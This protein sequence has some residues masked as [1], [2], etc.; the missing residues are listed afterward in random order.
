MED[1]SKFQLLK[2]TDQ[3]YDCY[4]LYLTD[5]TD[6]KKLF[7]TMC[8]GVNPLAEAYRNATGFFSLSINARANNKNY[9]IS[10][11]K[12]KDVTAYCAKVFGNSEDTPIDQ[13]TPTRFSMNISMDVAAIYSKIKKETG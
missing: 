1:A 3:T 6:H 4:K 13:I 8:S 11:V 12:V 7:M 5:G 9:V 2:L 10:H